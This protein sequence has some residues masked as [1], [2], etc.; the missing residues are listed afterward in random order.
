MLAL[1]AASPSPTTAQLYREQERKWICLVSGL[2]IA[3]LR[4]EEGRSAAAPKRVSILPNHKTS[5]RVAQGYALLVTSG[6]LEISG[7]KHGI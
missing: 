1:A 6:A 3:K 4:G 5:Q 2:N 7:R